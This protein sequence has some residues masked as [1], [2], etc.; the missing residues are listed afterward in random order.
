MNGAARSSTWHIVAVTGPFE[1]GLTYRLELERGELGAEQV[2][3]VLVHA[4]EDRRGD[5]RVEVLG[6]ELL[7]DALGD[8]AAAALR[9]EAALHEAALSYAVQTWG[10]RPYALETRRAA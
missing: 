10:G 3:L 2:A 5:D 4:F 6:A 9:G 7:G 1:D 8:D